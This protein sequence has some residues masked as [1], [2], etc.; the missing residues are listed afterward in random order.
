[1]LF[2]KKAPSPSNDVV[3]DVSFSDEER[4]L[5]PKQSFL[6]PGILVTSLFF[7]W[8]FSY[9]LLDTLNKH[10]KNVLG[11][12]TTESTYMQVA[13][14]GAYFIMCIPASMISKRFGYK[15]AMIFGLCLYVIGAICFYPSAV[16]LSYGGFVASLFIIASGLAT[17]ESTANTY[18]TAIGSRSKASLRINIAQSFNGLA[19]CV[20][21][22]IA[23]FAFFGGAE[24]QTTD[25][26]KSLDSVK[27][28]YIGVACGVAAIALLFCF[29][30]IPEIDEEAL[31]AEEARETGEVA[32]RASLTSPHLVLGAITEFLYTGAQVAVASMFLFYSSEVG[33]IPDSRGS[34]LLAIAQACFTIGRFV[35]AF[36]MKKIRPDHLMAIFATCCMISN[37]FV[38]AFKTPATTYVLFAI[39]FFESILFPTIF[40]LG[41]KDLG[42]NHKRGSAMIIM[43][44]SG[45]AV[46]PPL[47]G[48]AHD[49]SNVNIAF[50]IPLICYGV[51]LFYALVGSKWIK[52]VD[53]D[54]GGVVEQKEVYVDDTKKSDSK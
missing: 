36:L 14:F 24:D 49:H 53:E 28:T 43:G 38:I 44:V 10:F 29:A 12:T 8:G 33:Q 17:L 19:S 48:V 9:G 39:L 1:M 25:T 23:S 47:M 27:W 11:I 46:I 42:R 15:K 6:I 18:I 45:G 21:P 20:A 40:A 16:N 41:T 32:R 4:G 34:I 30:N 37:I 7:L 54:I 22:I 26:S 13:Y 51:V 35:G 5:S 52:Y 3:S 2:K 50:V 31:M